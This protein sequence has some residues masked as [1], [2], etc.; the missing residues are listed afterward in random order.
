MIVV[1]G[2]SGK[3]KAGL[4]VGGKTKKQMQSRPKQDI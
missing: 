3:E 2:E 1:W 4:G